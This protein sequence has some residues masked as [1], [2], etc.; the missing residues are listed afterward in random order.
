MERRRYLLLF[1]M[2]LG[3]SISSMAQD[4]KTAVYMFG[5][6]ASF[7]DS[8]VYMTD[9]QK[10]EDA[11]VNTKSG[12]LVNRDDYSY[13]LQNYLKQKGEQTPTCVTFYALKQKDI[14]K[15]YENLKK[16][17]TDKKKG[18]F[19]VTYLKSEDFAFTAVTPDEIYTEAPKKDKKKG[20][21]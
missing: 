15:K 14:H 9:I 8:T 11:W 21:K 2:L 1:V 18:D 12:F 13:Q 7:N 6:S 19:F 20:K 3:L 4:K 16:K 5:F 10:V 17:Y